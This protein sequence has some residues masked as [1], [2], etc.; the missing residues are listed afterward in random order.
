M[1]T[2][3]ALHHVPDHVYAH[4][5]A[6]DPRI[7]SIAAA[8]PCHVLG[9]FEPLP[10]PAPHIAMK[11][12]LDVVLA[13]VSIDRKRRPQVAGA[14]AVSLTGD[15]LVNTAGQDN[16][17]VIDLRQFSDSFELLT[18]FSD[19]FELLTSL[20]PIRVAGL[21]AQLEDPLANG[22]SALQR[23]YYR[24]LNEDT[25]RDATPLLRIDEMRDPLQGATVFTK[26]GLGFYNVL[27]GP[28][29]WAL[30]RPRYVHADHE[31]HPP[32]SLRQIRLLRRG[33]RAPP[34]LFP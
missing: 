15:P 3:A 18:S 24:G 25:I 23:H 26:V 17:P 16:P 29:V 10:S 11:D 1:A 9:H 5:P 13:W 31:R 22:S 4:P 19:S 21:Q 2:V 8:V 28:V 27:R 20:P 32:G 30:Q 33:R 12:N 6:T 34:S 14:A 7:A